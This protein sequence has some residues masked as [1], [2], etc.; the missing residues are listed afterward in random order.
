[1]IAVM[2]GSAAGALG[3][4]AYLAAGGGLLG[5]FLG[6]TVATVVLTMS[7]RWW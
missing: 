2:S 1:M 4:L 6:V 5:V 7:A 3:V